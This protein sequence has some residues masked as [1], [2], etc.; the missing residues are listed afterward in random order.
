MDPTIANIYGNKVRLRAC[1]ICWNNERLLLVNHRLVSSEDFWAPPGGGVEFG[2]SIEET[3]RREFREETGLNVE[4]GRFMFGCEYI[5]QPLHA[6]ELF[7]AVDIHSG[8]LAPG[9]D[10][11]LQIISDARFFAPDDIR[12]LKPGSAH[13]ILQYGCESRDLEQLGG[14]YRI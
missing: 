2:Q 11:E 10:P 13:G 5:N 9:A 12:R 14:F 6:V 3:I 8:D 7:F 4:V 1:G